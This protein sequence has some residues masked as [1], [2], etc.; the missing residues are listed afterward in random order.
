MIE[1]H[2]NINSLNN[3]FLSMTFSKW[4]FHTYG[5]GGGEGW[6]Q[7]TAQGRMNFVIIYVT[8]SVHGSPY[9]SKGSVPFD[10]SK[11]RFGVPANNKA[12]FP[13]N[14]YSTIGL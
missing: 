9:K 13:V 12:G 2:T 3:V 7:Y 10:P 8:K 1:N 6:D 11:P 14:F 4:R 5:K